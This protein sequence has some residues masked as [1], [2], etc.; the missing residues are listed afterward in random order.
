MSRQ[1]RIWAIHNT[2]ICEIGEVAGKPLRLRVNYGGE[3]LGDPREAGARQQPPY[4]GT[5]GILDF[6]ASPHDHPRDNPEYVL[7]IA[8]G[9]DA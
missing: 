8:L 2:Q 9:L 3:F 6:C 1:R 5:R 7:D 4:A